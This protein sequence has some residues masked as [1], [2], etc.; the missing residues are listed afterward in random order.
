MDFFF[1]TTDFTF[2]CFPQGSSMLLTSLAFT[3]G[4]EH[5]V[6]TCDPQ[7]RNPP[8]ST[9]LSLSLPLLLSWERVTLG[10][11]LL[12][13]IVG[14]LDVK[15][16]WFPVTQGAQSQESNE[17]NTSNV[18]DNLPCATWFI[19][20]FFLP[21]YKQS[22]GRQRWRSS[23]HIQVEGWRWGHYCVPVYLSYY[24]IMRP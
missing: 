11:D 8:P 17:R 16:I 15:N 4:T 9:L 22:S 18:T 6:W 13:L 20:F 10:C 7:C 2:F 14:V 23:C 5:I 24:H 12:H 21:S 3:F 19:F 1:L